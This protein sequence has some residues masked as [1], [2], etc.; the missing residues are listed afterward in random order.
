[1]SLETT[2]RNSKKP[3][4]GNRKKNEKKKR[5]HEQR[6][7]IRNVKME[8]REKPTCMIDTVPSGLLIVWTTVGAYWAAFEGLAWT[9]CCTDCC[10]CWAG[11]EEDGGGAGCCCCCCCCCG[12]DCCCVVASPVWSTCCSASVS[13]FITLAGRLVSS[14][15]SSEKAGSRSSRPW[16][17]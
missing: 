12:V 14:V 11:W 6:N 13:V 16:Y 10:W 7:Q 9:N 17:L 4:N 3:N 2:T 8:E 5:K 15:A 1:M